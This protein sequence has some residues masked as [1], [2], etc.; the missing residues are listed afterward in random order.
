MRKND[1]KLL[2]LILSIYAL[3]GIISPFAYARTVGD[4]FSLI[5]Y[6]YEVIML[7]PFIYLLAKHNPIKDF[8]IMMLVWIILIIVTLVPTYFSPIGSFGHANYRIILLVGIG[9]EDLV[10]IALIKGISIYTRLILL[11]LAASVILVAYYL[12]LMAYFPN[13]PSIVKIIVHNLWVYFIHPVFGV[14]YN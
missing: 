14:P 10:M 13:P 5:L 4:T 6:I 2:L 9:I 8:I 1:T 3:V 7:L 12:S 11:F